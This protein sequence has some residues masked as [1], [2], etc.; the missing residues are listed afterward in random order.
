MAWTG[1]ICIH[2]YY[3]TE[4][5]FFAVVS[6][7]WVLKWVW[8]TNTA[9]KRQLSFNL[10]H[11]SIIISSLACVH[12]IWEGHH[13]PQ[14]VWLT[15]TAEHIKK[16]N[17]VCITLATCTFLGMLPQPSYTPGPIKVKC[18]CLRIA[19]IKSCSNSTVSYFQ[20]V[21]QTADTSR[22]QHS[23]FYIRGQSDFSKH[24]AN[25]PSLILP[26]LMKTK[27]ENSKF[28]FQIYCPFFY[29]TFNKSHQLFS[30][31]FTA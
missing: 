1:S 29:M 12:S 15:Q 2:V 30:L 8:R 18:R 5:R 10:Q 20:V 13:V 14:M 27:R 6:K 3:M 28:Q 9:S 16:K 25:N 24:K 4:H 19:Q 7:P 11:R 22:L 31:C 21:L 26:L 17:Q 23:Q